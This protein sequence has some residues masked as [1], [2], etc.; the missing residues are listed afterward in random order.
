MSVFKFQYFDVQQSNDVHKVGTDSML[1]AA[2]CRTFH[3]A[4]I[5]DVGTGTGVIS[6]IMAQ[7]YTK[8]K[9]QAIELQKEAFLLAQKNFYSS[10]FSKRLTPIL[11]DVLQ[12]QF[13]ST[14]DLII[15]NPPFYKKG[16]P[17]PD[18]QR[19]SARQTTTFNFEL[20]F[21]RAYDLLNSKGNIAL[22]FPFERKNEL[23]QLG[24]NNEL[25]ASTVITV[26]GKLHHP[27]RCI[28]FFSKSPS[29]LEESEFTVRNEKGEY[30]DTYKVLTKDL[31]F[32]KL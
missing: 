25:Y 3:P 6:L 16:F 17:S 7:Y 30:T 21:K 9:I 4:E 29:I 11:G 19:N 32:N 13:D 18:A 2:F 5:L 26:N 27:S 1:L 10:P 24:R 14:F 28:V 20:F 31:H 8:A 23:L 12:Y 22:I 15:S